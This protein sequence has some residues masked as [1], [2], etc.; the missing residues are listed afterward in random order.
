MSIQLPPKKFLKKTDPGDPLYF[1]YIPV[2]GYVFKKRLRVTLDNLGTEVSNNLLEIGFGS[3]ILF[4]E[5]SKRSRN[6]YGIDFHDSIPLVREMAEKTGIKV[7]LQKGSVLA[8][9]YADGFFDAVVA[10]SIFE[11]IIPAEL[12]KAF[13]EVHRVM[14]KGGK[15]VISF[16]VRNIITDAFFQTIGWNS[17]EWNPRVMHPSSHRDIISA[18]KRH[19]KVKNTTV[20]PS[21]LPIDISLYNSILCIKE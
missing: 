1:H 21:W 9:P 7:D 20:F 4:P 12:D 11:H 13:I 6:L 18:A 2:I 16:P 14:K 15:A 5:L 3:G 19:F 10:V 17:K 8:L